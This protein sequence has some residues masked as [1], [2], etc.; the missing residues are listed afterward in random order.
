MKPRARLDG[1]DLARFL[2]FCGM[3]VVN[4]RLAM[5]APTVGPGAGLVL[6][7]EGRAAATFVVLAGVGLGLAFGDAEASRSRRVLLGRAAFLVAAGLLNA[8]VFDADILH[9]YG[10]YFVLGALCLRWR[11]RSLIGLAMGM[12]LGFVALATVL[13][14]E[15]GWNWVTLTYAD[16]W[17]PAGFLRHTF[18]NGWH[19]VLPWGAFLL[20]GMALQ[21]L[22][23]R[24]RAVQA[25]LT[26][27]GAATAL[28]CHWLA[29]ALARVFAADA[30]LVALLGTSP[31]PPGPLYMLGGVGT[32]VAVI[33]ACLLAAPA[34]ER[35]GLLGWLTAPGRQSL[36]L[37]IAHILLGMGTL[38][39]LDRLGGQ[40]LGA[41][42]TAA[43][44]FCALSVVYA[45]LWAR[46]FKRGPLEALMRRMV[47]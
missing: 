10:F 5:G 12:V 31:I 32:G 8:T 34:L 23:L 16:L 39:A 1:L 4:F 19:P 11:A 30:D 24:R 40:T 29:G 43:G 36:T 35:V 25:S 20:V 3:V 26:L 41:A 38:E 44:L 22:D 37:Y 42:L 28:T 46:R 17:T 6:A 21:R 47:G 7:L 9:F 14:Y 27:G 18:F 33:G 15:R 2:A 45:A 13:D